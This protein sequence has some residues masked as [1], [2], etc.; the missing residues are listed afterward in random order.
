VDLQTQWYLAAGLGALAMGAGALLGARGRQRNQIFSLFCCA[1]AL[2]NLAKVAE[3]S[4]VALPL[5]WHVVFLLGACAAAAAAVHFILL[6]GGPSGEPFRPAVPWIYAA[7]AALWLSAW[8]PA[9]RHQPA[10]NLAALGV[11]ACMILIGLRVLRRHMRSLPPGLHRNAARTMT[12]GAAVGALGALSDLLP[13]GS[14]GLLKVGPV[15][16]LFFLLVFCG[17]LLRYRFLD[18]QQ[19]LTEVLA[20]VVG[21]FVAG[22]LLHAVILL[23]GGGIL[24]LFV[25][26]LLLI[27]ARGPVWRA[28]LL[29]LRWLLGPGDP[30][31]QALV[32]VSR[33]LP[34]AREPAELWAAIDSGLKDLPG[35]LRVD[36]YLRGA[37]SDSFKPQFSSGEESAAAEIRGDAALPRLLES[38]R[39]PL[40]RQSLEE[41]STETRG[42]RRQRAIAALAQMQA[43][44]ADL[45]VPLLRGGF[46]AG[47]IAFEGERLQHY[48]WAELAA[49]FQAVGNQALANLD[50]IEALAQARRREALAAVGEMAA[51][52]AHEIRNPLGAIHGAAQILSSGTDAARSREMLTVIEEETGRLGRVM[53][54]FLEYARP[55]PGR[56]EPVDVAEL[57][58]GVLRSASASGLDLRAEV[59][60]S[61]EAS[62]ALGDPDQIQR[63]FANLVRNASDAA[64]PGGMLRIHVGKDGSGKI[65]VRFEDNGPGIPPEEIPRLF[66][67]FH[68]TKATGTGLGLALVHRIVEA[69]GGEIRVEGRQGLGAAFTIALPAASEAA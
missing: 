1:L 16:V 37:A 49:T 57:A 54:Q 38:R 62:R 29:G 27:A 41:E 2:W 43:L 68:T 63:A 39:C 11:F 22:M 58:R 32:A 65:T 48:P 42:E 26:L 59:R 19:F 24:P 31:A 17:V 55:A 13:R 5:A 50:R 9:Y 69:H 14:T 36:I 30:V 47:W 25:T 67:P 6:V 18:M 45:A 3:L 46:L 66:Q 61:S 64:G 53:G 33:E 44:R 15:A 10:W 40:T 35:N 52:L 20:I 4:G 34:Q 8:T 60:V 7:A 21:A 12:A 56:R 28:L 23:F 51:G